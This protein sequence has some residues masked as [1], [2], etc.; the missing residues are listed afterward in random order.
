MPTDGYVSCYDRTYIQPP[1]GAEVTYF[2]GCMRV[3]K[4]PIRSEQMLFSSS[5]W[6]TTRSARIRSRSKNRFSEL[7]MLL[8]VSIM[9]QICTVIKNKRLWVNA[10]TYKYLKQ[11]DHESTYLLARH[12]QAPF[13][14]CKILPFPLMSW[15][16]HWL[17]NCTLSAPMKIYN[18]QMKQCFLT[19]FT[20]M[21][22]H[23]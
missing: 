12:S 16:H 8:N 11:T 20:F 4:A 3:W 6:L 21:I 23:I 13:L 2:S 1:G 14:S 9:L 17:T 19:K 7:E 22:H 10:L 5:R 15:L 18:A